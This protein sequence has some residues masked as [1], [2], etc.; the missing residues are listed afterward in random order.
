VTADAARPIEAASSIDWDK[1][2]NVI[3]SG[4]GI[5]SSTWTGP[6][7]RALAERNPEVAT[8]ITKHNVTRKVQLMSRLTQRHKGIKSR[9]DLIAAK[10][11]KERKKR[12]K[13]NLTQRRKG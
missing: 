8:Q 9:P 2:M 1:P 5:D 4:Y 7:E 6:G 11:R 10:E 13:K 3:F 12:A